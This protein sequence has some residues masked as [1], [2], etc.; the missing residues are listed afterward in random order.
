MVKNNIKEMELNKLP[1]TH[2]YYYLSMLSTYT[3]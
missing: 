1:R 2:I 3:I